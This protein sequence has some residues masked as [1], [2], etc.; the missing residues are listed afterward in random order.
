MIRSL[1]KYKCYIRQ[2]IYEIFNPFSTFKK[3]GPWAFSGIVKVPNR[4]GDYIF[5]VTLAESHF[6]QP[7][8]EGINEEG[9]LNWQSQTQQKLTDPRIRDFINHDHLKNNIHL[10]FRLYKRNPITKETEP[11]TYLGKLAYITHDNEQQEPVYFKWQILEWDKE[12]T[13]A[14][15]PGL[16][17]SS[18]D[19]IIKNGSVIEQ[20]GSSLNETTPPEKN[21]IT[22][23]Q[24]STSTEF[25]AKKIDFADVTEQNKKLGL[26]GEKLVYKYEVEYLTQNGRYDLASQVSHTSIIE[27]DG[28]GFDISSFDL[29]GNPKYIEVKTTSGG[30]GTPFMISANEVAFSNKKAEN[31][32]IYRVF[33]YDKNTNTGNFYVLQGDISKNRLLVP[34]GYKVY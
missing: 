8:D 23:K 15:L 5:L 22:N 27:G 6:G 11:Y 24:G 12:A 33:N 3:G 9:I 10:F 14:S 32:Y 31:Y 21:R 19:Q 18:E 13:L 28:T 34:T 1:V 2:E 29:D 16:E 20:T 4:E 25:K 30:K 7:F 26:A 17:L